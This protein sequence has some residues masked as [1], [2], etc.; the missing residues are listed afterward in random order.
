MFIRGK[1]LLATLVLFLAVESQA[2]IRLNTPRPRTGTTDGTKSNSGDQDPC[3]G[4]A[5]GANP[6]Q[7]T[8][9]STINFTWDETINHPGRFLV[10]FS[11]QNDQGFSLAQ[12]E[13]LRKEDTQNRGSHNESVRLPNVTCDRCT[14]RLVQVMS[15]QPGQLYVQCVDIRLV[16]ATGP[17]PPPTGGGGGD[18]G[19]QS[20]QGSQEAQKD[21]KV[22]M[23]SGC[24][25]ASGM[26]KGPGSGSGPG[27][28][29]GLALISLLMPLG[30]LL[31]MRRRLLKTPIG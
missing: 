4:V 18:G 20:S 31:F 24:L 8:A 13:L 10:Q 7:L 25:F 29:G 16:A 26:I 14:L 1:F 3:G 11:L 15:D 12:N 17:T 6:L 21:N 22:E 30:L 23:P 2:H 9:G 5:R 27:A 19:G 28:S